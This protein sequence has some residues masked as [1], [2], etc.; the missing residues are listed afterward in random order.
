MQGWTHILY[1]SPYKL[2]KMSKCVFWS[3]S[4]F[5]MCDNTSQ[6]S[7]NG[8]QSKEARLISY[9]FNIDYN[10]VEKDRFHTAKLKVNIIR[11]HLVPAGEWVTKSTH[12]SSP[13]GLDTWKQSIHV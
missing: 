8:N 4:P 7:Q 6:V 3:S 13:P 9:T 12:L 10:S 2:M 1:S 11:Q 5:Q